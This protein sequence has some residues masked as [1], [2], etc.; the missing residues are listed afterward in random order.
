MSNNVIKQAA[1][2]VDSAVTELKKKSQTP[3]PVKA[4]KPKKTASQKPFQWD[5]PIEA[6]ISYFDAN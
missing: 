1:S 6:D 3:T 2:V 4:V 5:F